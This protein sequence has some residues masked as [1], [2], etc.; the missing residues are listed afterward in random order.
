MKV[1]HVIGEGRIPSYSIYKINERH[2]KPSVHTSVP[3]KLAVIN[4]C[5]MNH[6]QQQQ[7][8]SKKQKLSGG[9]KKTKKN[10]LLDKFNSLGAYGFLNLETME[11]NRYYVVTE[12]KKT[13][14]KYGDRVLAELDG[15][16]KL[17]LPERYTAFTERQLQ[18][19]GG[20]K[21]SLINKGLEG[22][23]Y[24]LELI[25]KE[26]VPSTSSAPIPTVSLA[27]PDAQKLVDTDE[28]D[29]DDDNVVEDGEVE[30][31]SSYASFAQ[32]NAFNYYSQQSF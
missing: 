1:Y 16:A 23:M 4:K 2:E 8:G 13:K 10:N 21:Y 26:L 30:E 5:I 15:I 32:P 29:D 31:E 28:D 3:D 27:S 11:K 14:S 25:P 9:V 12:L 17:Y 19:L 18:D 20:G 7:S 24:K 6:K 22:K